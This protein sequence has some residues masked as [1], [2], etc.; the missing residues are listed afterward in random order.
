MFASSVH[1]IR[2]LPSFTKPNATTG[3]NCP[4]HAC[5]RSSEG[6]RRSCPRVDARSTRGL[7]MARRAFNCSRSTIGGK[8]RVGDWV[9]TFLRARFTCRLLW[10]PP[11]PKLSFCVRL[12]DV[13]VG[14]NK[15]EIREI[16]GIVNVLRNGAPHPRRLEDPC[17]FVFSACQVTAAPVTL[18]RNV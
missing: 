5:Y 10:S 13:G 9:V 18:L 14:L 8:G 3:E 17:F 12:T 4:R 2:A 11:P 1:P 6:C 7:D 15:F 16:V